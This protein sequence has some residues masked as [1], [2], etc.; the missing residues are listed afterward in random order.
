MEPLLRNIERNNQIEP[1]V[2]NNLTFPKV[3]GYADDVNG[4]I[5]KTRNGLKQIFVEYE[6]LTKQS[7]LELNADKTELMLTEQ[8]FP[9]EVFRVRYLNKNYNLKC[10]PSIKING[11]YFQANEQDAKEMNVRRVVERIQGRLRQWSLRGLSILGKILIVKTFGISQIIF[12]MQTTTLVEADIKLFNSILYKFIWNK[13]FNAAKAPER[14]KRE[15]VNLPIKFGGFGMLDLSDL[16]DSI[17]MRSLGRLLNSNHPVLTQLRNKINFSNYLCPTCPVTTDKYLVRSLKLLGK[18]RIQG[19]QGN[20]LDGNRILNGLIKSISIKNL[21][22]QNGLNSLAYFRL[23]MNGKSFIGDLTSED[24][25]SL[26]R[27]VTTYEQA[28]DRIKMALNTRDWLQPSE[29]NRLT[30]PGKDKLHNIRT[31][32]SKDFRTLLN[33]NIPLCIFKSGN[34]FTPQDSVNYFD[35][36]SKLTCVAHRNILLRALHG[37]LYTNDR[38]NRFG[39]RNDPFCSR[40]GGVDTLD[41]RLN[42][43]PKVEILVNLLVTKTSK[44]G[45]RHVRMQLDTRDKLMANFSDVDGATLAV[46]AEALRLINGTS[47]LDAPELAIMRIVKTLISREGN[48][49]IKKKLKSLLAP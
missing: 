9:D 47:N 36:V 31:L 33:S 14:I 43:C 35:K 5:K 27:F 25:R 11:I 37:D 7:G 23:R 24:F 44:F 40:C 34:L 19:C 30:I 6:R 38:L 4:M 22:N 13:H 3:V 49:M 15:I 28:K 42:E 16:D 20:N 26:E 17:K 12:L 46:H 10:L 1:I 32:T 29:A 48:E 8:N 18:A 45:D 2:S 41:H 21:L 39:L